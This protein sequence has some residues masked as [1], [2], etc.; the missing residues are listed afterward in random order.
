[1]ENAKTTV[2]RE[3]K[4]NSGWTRQKSRCALEKWM[5]EWTL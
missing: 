4:E 1:M 3:S 2:K 5:D